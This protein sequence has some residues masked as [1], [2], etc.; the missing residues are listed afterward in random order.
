[1]V[2]LVR[3]CCCLCCSWVLFLL[4]AAQ[5]IAALQAQHTPLTAAA[6]L[7]GKQQQH[8]QQQQQHRQRQQQHRRW[9]LAAP[10][11]C[12]HR[13]LLAWLH[14]QLTGVSCCHR[15]A[16]VLDQVLATLQLPHLLSLL[17]HPSLL[18]PLL[19]LLPSLL[20]LLLPLLLLAYPLLLPPLLL[21]MSRLAAAH[22][23]PY[24]EGSG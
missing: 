6:E 1:M 2:G 3:A 23:Q 20:L 10:L 12:L 18:L 14:A 13:H 17:T 21:L 19:L 15:S 11:Q 8:Q 9:L 7:Q 24:S 4:Y 5:Q 16:P 22:R